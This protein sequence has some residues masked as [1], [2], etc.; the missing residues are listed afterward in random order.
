MSRLNWPMSSPSDDRCVA[1]AGHSMRCGCAGTALGYSTL[2]RPGFGGASTNPV[3]AFRLRGLWRSY[4][5]PGSSPSTALWRKIL[6]EL[7]HRSSSTL[8]MSGK[9]RARTSP[10]SI[11]AAAVPKAIPEVACELAAPAHGRAK[12]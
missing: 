1:V 5:P 11:A 8:C 6:P 7:G 3:T 12:D 10:A 9:P 2:N 4:L